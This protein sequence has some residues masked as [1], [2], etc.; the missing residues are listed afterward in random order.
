MDYKIFWCK[1]N[2]YYTE[3]WLNSGLLKDKKWIFVA[4]CIVTQ[5][6]KAKWIKF[7]KDAIKKLKEDEKVFIS[8]CAA[9][10][11][12]KLYDEFYEKYQELEIY[13]DKIVLLWEDPEKEWEKISSIQWIN[14]FL[15]TRKYIII[16]NW[17]D[18]YCTF[19]MTIQAR[20]SHY[21]RKSED[22]INEIKKFEKIW[23][24]EIVLTWTNIW[25]WWTENTKDYKNTKFAEIL[26][27]ILNKTTIE[28]IRISSL[29]I[30][31]INDELCNIIKNTRIYPHLHLSIQ[32]WSDKILKLMNRNYSKKEL[33]SALTKLRWIKRDDNVYLSIWA[34]FI[35]GFPSEDEEDFEDTLEIIEKFKITKLHAFP[36]SAHDNNDIIP[37]A[38]YPWQISEKIKKDR[39]KIIMEIWNNIRQDFLRDN[40]WKELKLLIEKC[41]ADKSIFSWWSENYIALNEKNFIAC[42]NSEIEIWNVIKWFYTYK[43]ELKER[44]IEE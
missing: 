44:F 32:S 13:K 31:Y 43:P 6:A 5:K 14:K 16:Q 42:T 28:R 37:A 25:A 22:I 35:V 41:N 12:W 11:K 4:S 7:V 20:W 39:M 38:K 34:D 29:G 27:D 21:S 24:K 26:N 2:K 23:W 15:Y 36:F 30:E 40:S 9:I 1:T 18:N 17:C 10:R 33:E 3:K 19:C 8:W